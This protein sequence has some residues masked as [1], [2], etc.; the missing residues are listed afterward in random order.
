M[1]SF[2][3]ELGGVSS[4]VS[5]GVSFADH[6][7]E[8]ASAGSNR[9][10]DR[11][12]GAGPH[13]VRT[14]TS[15]LFQIRIPKT[16]GGG[17]G[18]PLVRLGIGARP[19][20]D[21]RRIADLLAAAARTRFD[22][23]GRRSMSGD[24]TDKSGAPNADTS[25]DVEQLFSGET[26]DEVV[27]EVRGYLK[28]VKRIVEQDPRQPSAEESQAFAGMRGLVGIA[29]EIAKGSEGNSLIVDNVDV[30]KTK[31]VDKFAGTA[32][33]PSGPAPSHTTTQLQPSPAIPQPQSAAPPRPTLEAPPAAFVPRAVVR[34]EKGNIIPA[35]R[36]DR[37]TVPRPASEKPRFSEVSEE[38]LE[39]REAASPSKQ[40]DIN[41]ARF[42]R[43]LFLEL[44]GDHPVDTYNASDLQAY[45]HLLSFWPANE[46]DRRTDWTAREIIDDNRD[47]HLKPIKL[48]TFQDGY[49]GSIGTMIRHKMKELGYSDPFAN[50]N[51]RF[52]ET[53]APKRKSAPL[54]A[55]K[56]SAVFRI[57]VA[58][59]LL[60]E[61]MLPLLGHLT[62]R[63]LGLLIHLQGSD[64][65]D[66]FGGLFV[67]ETSGIVVK[68]GKWVR[69][70]FKTDAS[71]GF[72]VLH[73]FLK[74]IGFIDW[75]M[76][77]GDAFLFP[78][79]MNLHDPSK[80]ASSYM[81]RLFK[82]AGIEKGNGE[83]FHSLRGGNIDDM[84]D[85]KVDGRIRRIQVGHTVGGDE[86]EGYGQ[87]VLS[88]KGARQLALLPLSPEIDF[89]VFRGLPFD[90]MAARKR[91]R[92]R[93][94][95]D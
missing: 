84:R 35:Y 48:S 90:V 66:K 85:E 6:P 78:G 3:R 29:R 23:I 31:Y 75:A 58:S 30:L 68:D 76:K 11:P 71:T 60:D 93:R 88:E 52:P 64:I 25:V 50:A 55:E 20:A 5:R 59:G 16:L 77:Q 86:H 8:V 53:A 46:A 15:Y 39:Y 40:K 44:I 7:A 43:D 79:I 65:R 69:V 51:I 73:P 10:G 21:A 42:R 57:G 83:V 72:F 34:D 81:Q 14:G 92:G 87:Q 19:A 82:K 45:V 95:K 80:S 54:S 38:Y 67:A 74:E 63:R 12:R 4:R 18:S 1:E 17:R 41:T 49:V 37:R 28:A 94:P 56:I 91:T 22:E 32:L 36:L 27:V 26:P 61:A 2:D 89:S 9:T 47:M 33:S 70:P 62:G 24:K 13:L